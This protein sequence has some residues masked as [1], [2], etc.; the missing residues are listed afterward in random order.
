M[1]HPYFDIYIMAEATKIH[2]NYFTE[3]LYQCI[4]KA[5]QQISAN[6]NVKNVYRNIMG[7]IVL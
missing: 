1:V 5:F 4:L 3:I 2:R 6:V 7:S